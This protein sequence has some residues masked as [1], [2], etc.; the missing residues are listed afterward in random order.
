MQ[1]FLANYVDTLGLGGLWAGLII[2]ALGLPFP[3]GLM[4]MFAGFL[5][6]QNRLNFYSV[7]LVAVLA[8][9]MGALAAFYIGQYMGE[10]VLHRYGKFLRV[11]F[12]KWEKARRWMEQSAAVFIIIG[13]FVPMMSN[14]TPYMA[15][16]SGLKPT[17]FLL[18]NSI[19][20]VIWVS[21]NISVGMLFGHNWPAIAGYF[22]DRAPVAALVLV[23][24]YLA[25]KIT[26][27]HI[28]NLRSRK[29]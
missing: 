26:T 7:F 11:N 19:F 8:F 16:V 2:E 4:I 10:P 9:N 1:D 21:F 27:K 14:L 5:V 24:T 13:R 18:Y 15:G 22:N 12:N 6:N 17:R 20:S 25:V 23:L 3:G 29:V 28:H